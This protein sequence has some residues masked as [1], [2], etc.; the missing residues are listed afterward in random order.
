MAS[1]LFIALF[2][3]LVT[4]LAAEL[5]V[6]SFHAV[7]HRSPTLFWRAPVYWNLYTG[8]DLLGWAPTPDMSYTWQPRTL[9]D[10]SYT[11][12]Y[13]TDERGMRPPVVDTARPNLVVV[14]D[15]FTQAAQVNTG[16]AYYHVIGD[17]LGYDVFAF[18]AGGYGSL[19]QYLA[20]RELV[21]AHDPD[22]VLWQVCSNDF[23]NNSYELE[24]RSRINNVRRRRPYWE[25]GR[26][27]YRRPYGLLQ[28]AVEFVPRAV[29]FPHTAMG[30]V[31]RIAAGPLDIEAGEAIDEVMM[32]TEAFGLSVRR[33]EEVIALGADMLGDTP[34]IL[35]NVD[36]FRDRHAALLRD[37]AE[38]VEAPVIGSGL[39]VPDDAPSLYV[40]DRSHWSRDGHRV[41]GER[42]ARAM[43][44]L[45]VVDVEAPIPAE[46]D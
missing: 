43:A 8:D 13:R 34:L 42:V 41:V 46:G 12:Q 21:A 17:L 44:G 5:V 26:V 3:L 38:R 39:P 40:I 11:V 29:R 28:R 35:L 6:R 9:A 4:C 32:D 20:L 7:K 31:V 33:T 19:Q 27:R 18:G 36:D 2:A 24:R 14:G 25:D 23:V 16:E 15:S 10:E 45:G 30:L 37:I 22:V 1:G